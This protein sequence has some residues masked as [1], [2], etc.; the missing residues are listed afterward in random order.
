MT[1]IQVSAQQPGPFFVPPRQE[2]AI[3]LGTGDLVGS[4]HPLGPPTTAANRGGSQQVQKAP[5]RIVPFCCGEASGI[6]N[7]LRSPALTG[8]NCLGPSTQ[9]DDYHLKAVMRTSLNF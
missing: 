6:V 4:L 1:T 2:G 5:A 7:E 9:F 8:G 3:R